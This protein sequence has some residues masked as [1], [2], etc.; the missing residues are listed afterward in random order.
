MKHETTKTLRVGCILLI[1]FFLFVAFAVSVISADVVPTV[2]VSPGSA[3]LDVGQSQLFNSTPSGG[4]GTYSSYQW[5]VNGAAQSG[6]NASTFSFVPISVGSYLITATVTDSANTTS[7]QSNAASVTVNATLAAPTAT[8]TPNTV[9]QGQSSSLTS[10]AVTTGTA[11]YTY[12]W[13]EKAHNGNYVTVGA[14]SASFNFVT[15]G[16]TATGGWSF[17][18]QVTDSTAA[19]IN[20]TAASVTVNSALTAPT[21]SA[22][23]SMVDQGQTITLYTNAV[24]TGTSPYQYLWL[25][26]APGAGSFS[27]ISGATSSSYSF[28]TSGSTTT[29]SWSFELQ[30]TD[31]VS[32]VV[33]SNSVAVTVI[34]APSVSVSPGS[35]NLI[36]DQTKVFTATASGGSGNYTFYQWYV[37]GSPQGFQ[38][39]STFSFTP[40]SVGSYLITA[41]VAD[42]L[43]ATSAQST[44]ATVTVSAT[45]T[46]TPTP[47]P[48]QSPTPSPTQSPTPAPT[49]TQSTAPP[50]PT[51]TPTLT[52][53][54]SPSPSPSLLPIELTVTGVVAIV[55]VSV[56]IGAFLLG[57]RAER[58]SKRTADFQI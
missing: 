58:N 23:R 26:M 1:V 40:S 2:V 6:Q 43:S 31:S 20:S 45:A 32:A 15:S 48:T 44:A 5:Y 37:N 52:S 33:T 8:P 4:S 27:S 46:P 53:S 29:G 57:K 35:A 49:S 12:Q 9:N 18:L 55:I 28:V 30:V 14:N 25:E 19:A 17:I 24:L 42:N 21:A 13:F 47:V 51:A 39:P 11:P 3:T 34:V 10:S 54:S 16:S 50:S 56:A 36:V 41:T 22:S 38:L 7:A